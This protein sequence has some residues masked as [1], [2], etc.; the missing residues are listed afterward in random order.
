M[1]LLLVNLCFTAAFVTVF[2]LPP[3]YPKLSKD[4]FRD[5]DKSFDGEKNPVY[6]KVD[7]K[8]PLNTT[9]NL[10][11]SAVQIPNF[12]TN[13]DGMMI[14]QPAIPGSHSPKPLSLVVE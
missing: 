4:D 6:L 1:K 10:Q 9:S 3:Q 2:S 14:A 5:S 11:P 13:E 7:W 8:P 12:G